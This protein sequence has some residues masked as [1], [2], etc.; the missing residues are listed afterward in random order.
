MILSIKARLSIK[1]L[2]RQEE[3]GAQRFKELLRHVFY[4]CF[5]YRRRWEQRFK[6]LLGSSKALVKL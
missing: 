1:A 2:R 5:Y 3:M 6:A 4:Y